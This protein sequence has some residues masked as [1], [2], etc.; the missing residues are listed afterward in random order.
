MSTKELFQGGGG[1]LVIAM[2]VAQVSTSVGGYIGLLG[3]II[4]FIGFIKWVIDK[5]KG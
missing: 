1:I 2:I 5:L 3:L 4:I